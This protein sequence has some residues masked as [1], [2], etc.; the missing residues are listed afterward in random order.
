MLATA[1]S[2]IVAYFMDRDDQLLELYSRHAQGQEKYT[3]FLLTAAASA[4]AFAVVRTDAY[5]LNWWL[6]PAAVAV[7]LWLGSFFC[8]C[9]NLLWVNTALSANIALLELQYGTHSNQ[10]PTPEL[11]MAAMQGVRNALKSNADKGTRYYRLQ[12][13]LFVAGALCFLCWRVL[14]MVRMTFYK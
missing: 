14:D 7:A 12:F 5:L 13:R 2:S 8:G 3:Y 1:P 4:I 6:A 9:Q 10:P 11:V